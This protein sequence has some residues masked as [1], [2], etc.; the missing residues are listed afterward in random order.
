GASRP[1]GDGRRP[2]V[3][4]HRQP[5]DPR[6]QPIDPRQVELQRQTGPW[7]A[8]NPSARAEID[9]VNAAP[10]LQAPLEMA[11]F[12]QQPSFE[13]QPGQKEA[14]KGFNRRPAS[15]RRSGR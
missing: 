2:P 12:E 4:P 9:R 8:S 3:D 1:A 7:W 10:L 14:P 6:R 15:W 13:P 5:G 11:D